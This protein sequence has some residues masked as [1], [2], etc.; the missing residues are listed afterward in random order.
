MVI[1]D[2]KEVTSA[3]ET[4]LKEDRE[5]TKYWKKW[6]PYTAERQWAT[7]REDYSNDGDAWSSFTYDMARSRAFRWGEDGIA[8]VSDTHGR[9]NI[10]FAFWNENDGH[11]KER[12]FG[13]SNPQGVHGESIKECHFHLD[14]TPTH[15][16]MKFL[17]KLPQRAFP[18]EDLIKENARRSRQEREYNLVDTGIFKE[19][20][21]WDIFIETAK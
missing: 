18:Y 4:R 20:R 6:G 8:G 17:Y 10:A 15:S 12:L 7:V 3:E 11:L 21:Y 5:R 1:A 14:N 13:L 9:M 2:G 16:Y 19:D